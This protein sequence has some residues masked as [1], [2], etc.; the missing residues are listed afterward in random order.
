MEVEV[1][2]EQPTEQELLNK[3]YSM[4]KDCLVK[5]VH[6]LYN[7][8]DP[9]APILAVGVLHDVVLNKLYLNIY[10]LMINPII[11]KDFILSEED[12]L[13]IFKSGI[14]N[15]KFNSVHDLVKYLNNKFFNNLHVLYPIFTG[16]ANV[17]NPSDTFNSLI[18]IEQKLFEF[19]IVSFYDSFSIETVDKSDIIILSE[20]QNGQVF[21][22]KVYIENK[23]KFNTFD[24]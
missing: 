13:T 14:T 3:K 15:E 9:V 8:N 18:P 21:V 1:L 22:N 17:S 24:K 19:P 2:Q 10:K 11:L 4:L 7:N 6:V 16:P 23:Y 20:K 12:T 5:N